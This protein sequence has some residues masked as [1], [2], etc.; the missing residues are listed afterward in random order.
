MRYTFTKATAFFLIRVQTEIQIMGQNNDMTEDQKKKPY[1]N[2][3]QGKK[4]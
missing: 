4:E 1:M 2:I 3:V